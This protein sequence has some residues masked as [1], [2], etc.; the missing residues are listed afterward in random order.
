MIDPFFNIHFPKPGV[1][2]GLEYWINLQ[3]TSQSALE[4]NQGAAL[5]FTH[6]VLPWM[7][8]YLKGGYDQYYQ[9]NADLGKGFAGTEN[10]QL[11]GGLVFRIPTGSQDHKLAV[12]LYGGY[13]EESEGQVGGKLNYTGRTG[14]TTYGVT[15]EA[16]YVRSNI[17]DIKSADEEDAQRIFIK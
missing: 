6:D 5:Q 15:G 11:L 16:K 14:D 12:D 13:G 7:S 10:I 3:K 17:S 1:H 2:I 9:L 8:W 4:T